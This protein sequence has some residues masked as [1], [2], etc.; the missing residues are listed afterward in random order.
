MHNFH[1]GEKILRYSV[2]AKGMHFMKNNFSVQERLTS[3]S[4]YL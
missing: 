1:I 4:L 3:E 2:K